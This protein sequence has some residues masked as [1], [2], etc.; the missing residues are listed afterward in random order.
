MIKYITKIVIV[1]AL[2]FT[3]CTTTQQTSSS[4]SDRI[5]DRPENLSFPPLNPIQVP[6]VHQFEFNGITFFLVEDNEVPLINLNT[7]IRAGSWMEPSDKVGL[8]SM[9]G[10]IM[11]SGGTVNMPAD[12][13]NEL[14][15][16]RAASMETSFGLT[17]GNARMNVLKEDFEELLPVFIELLTQPA[18][19][20]ERL[21][22]SA[23]QRRSAISRRNDSPSGI[24]AREF[25]HLIY[26]K[27]TVF[28]SVQE[29]DDLNNISVEDLKSFHARAV[30]AN[31]LLVGISGDFTIEEIKPILEEAFSRVEQGQRNEIAFPDVDY[32]FEPS[33]NFI[34][35]NDMNQSIIRMGHIGGFRDNPD[36]AALQVMNQILSSGFSGRLMQEV[37]TRLGLAYSVG[38]N[39]GSGIFFQGQFFAGL[40]TASESTADAINATLNEIKR[41]Q[42]EPVTQRE[43]DDTRE[44]FLNTLV[45]RN[46]SRAAAL[47]EQINNAYS[48]L[49]FDAFER[50]VE[51]VRL[52]TP[53]DIQRVA[54]EYLR[55]DAVR[56]LVVGNPDEI[57]NQLDEFGD[58]NIIDISIPRP[59][60]SAPRATVAG[61]PDV[62]REWFG[63]MKNAVLKGDDVVRITEKSALTTQ[64]LPGM[65]LDAEI[66]FDFASL[67]MTQTL[68]T[69]MGTIQI[70]LEGNSGTQLFGPQSQDLPPTAVAELRKMVERHYI[71]LAR[72]AHSMQ[73]M[74]TGTEQVD[75]VEAA[76][77]YLPEMDVFVA[78]NKQ[79]ALPL[80]IYF[81]DFNAEAGGD[82]ERVIK[83]ENWSDSGSIARPGKMLELIDGEVLGTY[84]YTGYSID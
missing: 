65:T 23:R 66:K 69:P 73:A 58:V 76:I 4:L 5:V 37:R 63:R 18:F 12:D 80:R 34:P 28:S 46:E 72:N 74:Y 26:G 32:A 49:P 38:G 39:F 52:V 8:A 50:Y 1:T 10:E 42:D 61:D 40:S 29:Y 19:P 25:R 57:G 17:S 3:G 55:P 64:Q 79:S 15:E 59:G 48:G 9:T 60:E 31:N 53:E 62:G 78:L 16:S 33:I 30:N 44:R 7:I 51:Q 22:L 43:L 41:I 35:R 67:N 47:N 11:R 45:F 36:Y 77:I 82:I 20:E 68:N 14:L 84:S 6:E 2:I 21:E 75:G 70:K 54:N 27:Q 71:N 56:I 13:L 24:A 83:Y 81:D